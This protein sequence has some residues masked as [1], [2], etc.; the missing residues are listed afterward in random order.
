MSNAV[1]LAGKLNATSA[2]N[3]KNNGTTH[4][5]RYL[6]RT[7]WKG[8]DS[9]EVAA[10]KAAGL[11]IFS[12]YE[13]N[14]TYAG[15]FSPAQGEA[16]AR[17]AI[18]L[19]QSIGQTS[20]AAIYFTVDYDAQSA[21]FPLILSYFQAVRSVLNGYKLGAYGSYSVLNYLHQNNAADYYFQTV[22]WS[23]GQRNNFLNI[24]QYQCDK[25][26]AGLNVD[27]DNLEQNDIG[28]WG[29]QAVAKPIMVVKVLQQTDVRAEPSHTSGYVAE[30]CKDEMYNVWEHVGDWCKIIV[31]PDR[32]IT[33]WVD[34]NN[35]Q[36]L[37][38]LDNPA[39]KAQPFYYVIQS[40]DILS[41][42]AKANG[43]TVSQLQAWNGISDPNKI[44]PG[45]KIRV[46]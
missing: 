11:Q 13:T 2:G 35:G 23:N 27:L 16:D 40:G 20:G 14:P 39:L 7:N 42:I 31:D 29:Q 36:N 24:Y 8:L 17:E 22:A 15:Y 4:V 41:D 1:D 32:N 25:T 21:D 10:I 5:G 12:I 44:F 9:N 28:A 33:G 38:W 26:F 46:K 45:Q 30:A 3:L 37:Y 34:G 43:T 18:S 6:S 19:A